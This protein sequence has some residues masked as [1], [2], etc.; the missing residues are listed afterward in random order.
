MKEASEYDRTNVENESGSGASGG[1][2][3]GFRTFFLNCNIISGIEMISQHTDLLEKL[4]KWDILIT[5]EG[6]FDNQTFEGKVISYLLSSIQNSH[7]SL[8]Y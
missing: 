7:G 4:Y 5:G 3:C 6:K 2:V 1:I 8:F